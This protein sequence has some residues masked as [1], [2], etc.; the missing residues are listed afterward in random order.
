RD[1]FVSQG[2][3]ADWNVHWEAHNPHVHVML[4]MRELTEEGFGNKVRAWN[5]KDQ[6]KLWREKWAEY[7][8]F[9]LKMHEHGAQIDHRSYQDQ[10]IELIPNV[11]IGKSVIDMARRGIKTV[12]GQTA[13]DIQRKN[14]E[15]ILTILEQHHAVFSEKDIAKI[16]FE[17]IKNK[18]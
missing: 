8:N 14:V 6:I 18:T 7:A 12:L 11:R 2:M 16:I 3:V 17:Q 1:Q 13:K 9:H 4:T 15:K 10:G 5:Q